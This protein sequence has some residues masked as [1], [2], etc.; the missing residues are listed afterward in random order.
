MPLNAAILP[1]IYLN[2]GRN[3]PI[4]QCELF[5]EL[6]L[7][8]IVRELQTRQP[9]RVLEDVTSF[10]DLPADLK[11]QLHKLSKVAFVGMRQNKIVLTQKELTSLSTLGLLHS[12]QSFGRIGSKL[13]TCTFIHLTV[14]DLAAY[15]ISQME[16]DEHSIIFETLLKEGRL[17][18]T[19]TLVLQFYAGQTRLTVES[20][21]NF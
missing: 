11:D 8:C 19:C 17:L 9:D 18:S 21:R 10:E 12:V 15:Y 4:T 7:C 5:K 6:V 16:T 3:L 13:V 2:R 14:Q 20:A 1:Y